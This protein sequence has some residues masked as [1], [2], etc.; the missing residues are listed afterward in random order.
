MYL[1]GERDPAFRGIV[2]SGRKVFSQK[3][4]AG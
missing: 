3:K 4:E 2:A 1:N